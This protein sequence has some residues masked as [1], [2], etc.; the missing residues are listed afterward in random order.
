MRYAYLLLLR[1]RQELDTARNLWREYWHFRPTIKR[2]RAELLRARQQYEHLYVDQDESPLVSVIIPTFNRGQLLVER[3]LPSV[4]NQSYQNFEIVI[5]G[6]HCTD[7]TDERLSRLGDPRIRFSNL[8][9]RG[10]YPADP[11]ARWRV[12]GAVPVNTAKEMAQGK[13]IAP[14]DDDDVFTSDHIEVLLRYAQ[15]HNLEFVYGKFRREDTPGKWVER[16]TSRFSDRI[17]QNSATLHR[18]YLRL[19]KADINAWRIEW[20]GEKHRVWRMYKAG[21]RAG[22]IDQVVAFLPLRPGQTI[23]GY[24]AEDRPDNR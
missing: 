6:D 8:P 3:T 12:A 2:E 21:V 17:C 22:F 23:S 7:D 11:I 24:R 16:G 20:P 10:E 4:L 15:K 18:T 14:L 5:V 19:F 13:W 9:V 1:I